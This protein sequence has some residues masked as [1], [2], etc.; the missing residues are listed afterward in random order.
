MEFFEP[1]LVE[2]WLPAAYVL[3]LGF[4]ECAWSCRRCCKP[5]AESGSA[6]ESLVTPLLHGELV[7]PK[8]RQTETE[9]LLL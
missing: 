7:V 3:L 4:V 9:R 6:D 2:W 1:S 8:H 5:S